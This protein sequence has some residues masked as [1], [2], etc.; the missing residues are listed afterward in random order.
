[1]DD[2][3]SGCAKKTRVTQAMFAMIAQSGTYFSSGDIEQNKITPSES[4]GS[5]MN[6]KQTDTTCA[7][8]IAYGQSGTYFQS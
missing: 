6:E 2:I 8:F 4:I 5:K 3:H 7:K 1:M